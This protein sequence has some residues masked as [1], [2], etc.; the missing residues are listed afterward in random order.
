MAPIN[1][2]SRHVLLRRTIH[3]S[4]KTANSNTDRGL[5]YQHPYTKHIW[6]NPARIRADSRSAGLLFPFAYQQTNANKG[7]TAVKPTQIIA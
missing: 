7:E 1:T 2:E 3:P 6:N 4:T 5:K